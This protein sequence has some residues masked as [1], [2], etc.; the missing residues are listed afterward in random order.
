MKFEEILERTSLRELS[1]WEA[2]SVLGVSERTFRR[3]RDRFEAE[4]AEGL[5]DRRLGRVSGRRVPVD[6]VMAIL[7]LFDTRYFDFTAKHFWEKLVSEHD[8][9]RS[10]NWLRLTLQAHGR[11]RKA[12]RRGAHRRKRPRRPLPGMMLHQDGSKHQ[13]VPGQWWTLIVTMDDATSEIFSAFFVAEE[14]TMSSFLGLSEVISALGLFCALYADRASHYWYT[15]KAGGKVDRDNPTQVGRALQQLGIE[16]IPAYSPEARGRSERMFGTLQ[17][18][19]PQELRLAGVTTMEAANRFLREHF[20]AQH[21]SRFAIAPE[22]P[23]SAYVP[24]AG[25]LDDILCIQEERTV[26]GD[27]TVRY[28]G[29]VLQIPADRHRHH[30]VKAKVRVH[31]YPDASLAI[32]HGPR[33]LVTFEADGSCRQENESQAA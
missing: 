16:L 31:E 32:F 19:L 4:G 22:E 10:Y 5:Y 1:Q 18:R 12:P 28:K 27:N 21:N 9:K 20:L 14:G 6:T 8:F 30:Y 11:T 33:R 26:A 13:W 15:S 23:G 3:W 25:Q 24:F 17:K 29:L 7:E 2:A